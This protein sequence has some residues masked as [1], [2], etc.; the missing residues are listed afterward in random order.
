[1]FVAINYISCTKEYQ[2]RFEHLMSTR[3][4]EIDKM[5]GFLNMKVLKPAKDN[6]DYLIIS[7][8]E[9]HDHFESWRNSPEFIKGH[10]RGFADISKAGKEGADPP[11]KSVFKT[12]NVLTE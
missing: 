12:Y 7:H 4:G 3:A 5:P 1:M 11:M 9:S 8:W 6:D 10:Q 2:P